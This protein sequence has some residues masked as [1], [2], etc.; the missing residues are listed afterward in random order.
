MTEYSIIRV[1]ADN[2]QKI[3]RFEALDLKAACRIHLQEWD[4]R[5]TSHAVVLCSPDGSRYSYR[6]SKCRLE[7]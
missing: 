3:R 6:E 4:K 7:D 2:E 5:T 1:S